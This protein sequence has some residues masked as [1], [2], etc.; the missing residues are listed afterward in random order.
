VLS[1]I[2]RDGIR[3]THD[4]LGARISQ[5]RNAVH[6][7]AVNNLHDFANF[8]RRY[9]S[10]SQAVSRGKMENLFGPDVQIDMGVDH[11]PELARVLDH[12]RW[13]NVIPSNS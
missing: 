11:S 2:I 7:D 6:L 10:K 8:L 4:K 9:I 13:K 3:N 1:A 12:A 5:Y